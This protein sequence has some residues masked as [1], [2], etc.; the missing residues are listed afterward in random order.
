M[1]K[2]FDYFV[3][4]AE[5]RTGSNFLEANLNAF[6]DVACHGEAFNPHFIG[7]P[8]SNAIHEVTLAQ[9]E[10]DPM[11]L[12]AAIRQQTDG[13]GGFRY[14]HDHDP[15][16][17]DAML[18][19]PRCAKIVLTRNPAESYVSW[20]I[21]QSTGQWKLTD[22]KKR[23][24]GMAHFS[25]Q[26]F[27]AHLSQLQA[28][29]VRILNALQVSGQTAFYL[30]YEDL[31]SLE[32]MNGL[33]RWLG[34][35]TPLEA[36][37]SKLKKQNPEPLSAKVENFD[38]ME[39]ALS[40]L[41]RFNLTRTPNFEPRRGGAVPGYVAGATAPI[42]YMPMPGGPEEQMA[43][44]LAAL[45]GVEASA[46]RGEFSQK[47]LRQW[48]S[49]HPGFR[50]LTILRHPVARVHHVFC[51]RILC[52]GPGAFPKIRKT[53]CNLYKLPLPKSGIPEGYD[54]AQH[55]EAF[56][57]FLSFVQDNIQG[58]T[59]QR[60]DP[61]WCS[62]S[63][64]L[65]GF[66]GVGQPDFVLREEEMGDMLPL[67]ARRLG[68]ENPPQPGMAADDEPVALGRIYDAEIEAKVR[69]IYGRDYVKFGFGPWA[70]RS[71]GQAA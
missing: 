52:D 15:R 25:D 62:Q 57:A 17:L 64:I 9:R 51:R 71:G 18:T 54:A 8:N 67:V 29:Q 27:E 12:L 23:K 34:A 4:F 42:L 65:K 40:G 36:L 11:R 48:R 38:E 10:A 3:V 6:A 24:G 16:I 26:E 33:G 32:I 44:W 28:F 69:A 63:E 1:S 5:M 58:Q 50:S 13:L 55:K 39:Q 41:D 30:D 19:D 21:A 59:S 7:Y 61:N 22:M 53:L 47:T 68:Y 60:I 45:D 49:D 2:R 37:D 56:L 46:L 20:K 14:F 43:D 70:D 31:Q 35:E 66:A